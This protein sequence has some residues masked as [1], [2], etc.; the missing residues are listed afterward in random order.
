MAK[1]ELE[2]RFDLAAGADHRPARSVEGLVEQ[3][4][5]SSARLVFSMREGRAERSQRNLT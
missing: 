5:V 1:A 3:K 2:P 4:P